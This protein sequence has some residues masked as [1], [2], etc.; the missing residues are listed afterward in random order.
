MKDQ[1]KCPCIVCSHLRGLE[2]PLEPARCLVAT[3]P[4]KVPKIDLTTV[5]VN[6]LA[7]EL[8]KR[9]TADLERDRLAEAQQIIKNWYARQACS[10]IGHA[11]FDGDTNEANLATVHFSGSG[12]HTA[13]IKYRACKIVKDRFANA[14]TSE[15]NRK[16]DQS[17]TELTKAYVDF[18][19]NNPAVII[20]LM[21]DAAPPK[22]FLL[23]KEAIELWERSAIRVLTKFP[24]EELKQVARN[25]RGIK[26]PW[27]WDK[28]HVALLNKALK[29]KGLE[30]ADC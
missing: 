5:D 12:G 13:Y 2:L 22:S 6:I 14:C 29:A 4:G 24:V 3:P 9:N 19:L 26:K 20:Q 15:G 18:Q 25:T 1:D 10:V 21:V 23:Y 8:D 7:K 27:S 17:V 28:E 30:A 11:Y 16:F